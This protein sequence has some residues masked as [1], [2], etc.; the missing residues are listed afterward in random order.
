MCESNVFIVKDGR[1][2]KVLEDVEILK[3]EG[4]FFLL[5]NI[6]GEQKRVKARLLSVDFTAHKVLLSER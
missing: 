4:E 2:E 3:P 1:E 6:H 5:A